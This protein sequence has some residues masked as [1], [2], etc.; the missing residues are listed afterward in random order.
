M[1][2]N[3]GNC[4]TKLVAFCDGR[5]GFVDERRVVHVVCLGFSKVVNAVSCN[6]HTDKLIKCR[7]GK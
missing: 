5:A 3:G 7:L 2:I 1:D 4:L 6:I